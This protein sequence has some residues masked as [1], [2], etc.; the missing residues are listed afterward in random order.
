MKS[1]PRPTL[2]AP[3]RPPTILCIDDDPEITRVIALQL[4][5]Y[6]VNVVP[7]LRGVYGLL[8]T[9]ENSPDLILLDLGMPSGD[10]ETILD[11]VRRNPATQ[12][13]P[14]IILTGRRNAILKQHL[15]ARGANEYLQK[16]VP[17]QRL[18]A[19]FRRFV[20][21]REKPRAAVAS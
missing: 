14:V 19:E 21:V 10:G 2:P 1:S 9:I 20:A 15:L 17:F 3:S 5:K 11:C 6:D 12:S 13:T 8:A 7:A 18:L 4:D 16:P